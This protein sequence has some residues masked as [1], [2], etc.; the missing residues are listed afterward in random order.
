[1]E[2]IIK[3]ESLEVK[4]D[5]INVWIKYIKTEEEVNVFF[6]TA[7]RRFTAWIR[8]NTVKFINQT[9]RY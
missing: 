2:Q 8:K 7:T 9:C 5:G 1:M 4:L 3:N 6:G